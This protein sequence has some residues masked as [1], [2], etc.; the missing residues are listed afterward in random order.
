MEVINGI[1][2]VGIS[3]EDF[4]ERR[5]RLLLVSLLLLVLLL[6]LVVICGINPPHL[7]ELEVSF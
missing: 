7:T 2:F 3:V 4:A 5:Y 1:D 6:R